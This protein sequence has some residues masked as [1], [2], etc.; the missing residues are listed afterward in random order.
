MIK[1]Q[2]KVEII[3]PKQDNN[4]KEVND[5]NIK[6]SIKAITGKAGGCTVTDVEGYW[7]SDTGLMIDNNANYEW[8]YERKHI[9]FISTYISSIVRTLIYNFGQEGVSVKVNG[10][11]YI[12]LKE[13]Y[14][15][16]TI[17]KELYKIL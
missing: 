1:L 12:F 14:D 13:D 11:L 2:N 9:V 5:K 8:Y 7:V 6:N 17:F 3:I 10:N 15:N 4:G 16:N